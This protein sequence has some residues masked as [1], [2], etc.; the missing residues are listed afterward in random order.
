MFNTAF[1]QD[2][3]D[4]VLFFINYHLPFNNRVIEELSKVL[5]M[6]H[7]YRSSDLHDIMVNLDSITDNVLPKTMIQNICEIENIDSIVN[8]TIADDEIDWDMHSSI[9]LVNLPVGN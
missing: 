9:S 8:L 5:F 3:Y 1:M 4:F 7:M 2:N 6:C